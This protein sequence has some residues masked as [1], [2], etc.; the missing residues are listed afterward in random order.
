MTSKDELYNYW[1]I[2]TNQHWKLL[3]FMFLMFIGLIS[4][5]SLI[6]VINGKWNFKNI[7]VVQLSLFAT[8][9]IFGSLIWFTQSVRCP[10]CG[11][12]PV[13]SVIKSSAASEW[14][15]GIT[16]LEHCPSCKK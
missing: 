15:S 8:F 16:K 10:A 12:K 5:V 13:W 9:F 1:L 14:L 4:F 3:T 7:D 11:Y 2:R 6:L